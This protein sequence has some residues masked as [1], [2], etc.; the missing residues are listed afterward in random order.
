V[1]AVLVANKSS[2]VGPSAF[3][4]F[5]RVTQGPDVADAYIVDASAPGDFCVTADIPLAAQLV[6]KGLVVL[7][8]RGDLYAAGN[9]GERLA[10]RDL[11]AALREAG[12]QTRRSTAFQR[13]SQAEIRRPLRSA[14]HQ[15]AA[16]CRALTAFRP[17]ASR[18]ADMRGRLR[19][20]RDFVVGRAHG[21]RYR[22]MGEAAIG[23]AGVQAAQGHRVHPL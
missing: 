17:R 7:D 8:P 4:S 2:K 16:R 12:V 10:I 6:D 14:Y 21:R 13:Q 23:A 1:P 3:V 19:D 20:R 15:G 9:V 5:V 18:E 11:M 22:P